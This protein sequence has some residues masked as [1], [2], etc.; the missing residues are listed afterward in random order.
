MLVKSYKRDVCVKGVPKTH[1]VV[2]KASYERIKRKATMFTKLQ[3]HLNK[4]KQYTGTHL[5]RRILGAAI[6]SAP[7]ASHH[8]LVTLAPSI[9]ASVLSDA[10]LPFNVENVANISPSATTLKNIVVDSAV[11]RVLKIRE[12]LNTQA[13]IYIMCDKGHCMKVGHFVKILAW[14]SREEST[15]KTST[16]DID[17]SGGSSED[18]SEA[19]SHSLKKIGPVKLQGQCMGSVGGGTGKSLHNSLQNL[20]MT[21]ERYYISFCS[22]HILQLCLS[23]PVKAV[24]GEGG[25]DCDGYPKRNVMQLVHSAYNLQDHHQSDLFQDLFRVV[26]DK[27]GGNYEYRKM[28]NPVLT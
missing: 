13:S 7:Q 27:L 20:G 4:R 21:H 28:P 11:D 5:G 12:E 22:L 2:L 9:L 16:L 24:F 1:K 19:I 10:G 25:L 23:N 18:C 8:A 6:A 14:Y 17:A 15:V 26:S 3:D